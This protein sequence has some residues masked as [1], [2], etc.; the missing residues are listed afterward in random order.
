MKIEVSSLIDD[1]LVTDRLPAVAA[2]LRDNDE[3]RECWDRYCLIGDALRGGADLAPNLAA[4]VAA[5][6]RNDITV[7]AP[8]KRRGEGLMRRVAALAASL[9]GIAVVGWV[10]LSPPPQPA[11]LQSVA[12][13]ASPPVI[14]TTERMR[15]YL[16]AHQA[17]SPSSRIQGGASYIRTISSSR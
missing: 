8:S 6:L 14:A 5:A 16:V 4:K 2:A 17:Y 9:A 1:E 15:E 7:L 13:T 12:R 3:L 10:A 11:V